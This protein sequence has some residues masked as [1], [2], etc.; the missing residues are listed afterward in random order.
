MSRRLRIK[1][2]FGKRSAESGTKDPKDI[3]VISIASEGKTEEQYFDGIHDM[4]SS[5]IIK[6][7]RLEKS[8]KY[9]KNSHPNHIIELLNERKEHWKEH[10]IEPN[11]LWMVIDRDKK[12][13]SEVQLNAIIEK[14]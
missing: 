10:G 11:E 9:D 14:C 3:Y 2:E 1:N 5:D 13:V 7:E 6:I 8:E 4:D 12:N